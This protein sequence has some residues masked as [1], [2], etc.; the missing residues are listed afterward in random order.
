V[1]LESAPSQANTI[2]SSATR[3][4]VVNCLYWRPTH[5][6][7]SVVNGSTL[8]CSLAH[9]SI[10]YPSSCRPLDPSQEVNDDKRPRH[11][12]F[13]P[14][15]N[16]PFSD[17]RDDGDRSRRLCRTL[18]VR[19]KYR[20]GWRRAR[21]PLTG[22]TDDGASVDVAAH[23]TLRDFEFPATSGRRGSATLPPWP[24]INMIEE[25]RNSSVHEAILTQTTITS[26]MQ[27]F[28]TYLALR[29]R[30]DDPRQ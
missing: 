20:G 15:D 28:P 29:R 18:I 24:T 22:W 25:R 17:P 19:K 16:K 5:G 9:S 6:S 8:R 11:E 3:H 12:P 2:A 27:P 7:A 26:E 30:P 23:P 14:S 10:S 13:G 4:D 21:Q 1:F